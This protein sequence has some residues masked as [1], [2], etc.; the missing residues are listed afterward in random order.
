MRKDIY[1]R[2][3][4]SQA[5]NRALLTRCQELERQLDIMMQKHIEERNLA[6]WRGILL[7][8]ERAKIKRL[9]TLKAVK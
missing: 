4:E 3:E 2:L 7:R 9:T 8:D 1:T 6:I 5:T